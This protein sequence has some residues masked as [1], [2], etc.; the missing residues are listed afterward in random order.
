MTV[1]LDPTRRWE[2]PSCGRQHVTDKPL[3]SFPMH[4]CPSQKGLT[5]PFVEVAGRE[6][7][8]LSARH[9]ILE[10]EDYVGSDLPQYDD[11]HRPVMAV[12]TDHADGSHDCAV[13]APVARMGI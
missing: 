2:C 9:R 6:L 13:L 10:R 3:S 4:P 1:L 12:V 8:K 7:R 5:V 11:E